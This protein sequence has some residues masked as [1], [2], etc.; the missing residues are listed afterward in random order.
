MEEV[1]IAVRLQSTSLNSS[2]VQSTLYSVVPD[3]P[4]IRKPPMM[5]EFTYVLIFWE[6]KFM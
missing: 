2:P 6:M 1:S 4:E 5:T 3:V